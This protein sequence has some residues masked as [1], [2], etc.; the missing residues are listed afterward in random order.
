MYMV[1]RELHFSYGHRLLNYHGKCM[2][3]HGHNARLEID[4]G[5]D[6][7]DP[8]GM[9]MDFGDVKAV[10]QS[11]I[12]K[13]LDHRMIL[14]RDDPLLP[15]LQSMGEPCYVVFLSPRQHQRIDFASMTLFQ[16]RWQL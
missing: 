3:P 5:A 7:L 11:W 6:E 10:I 9:V 8:R 2:H 12:D 13:E 15:A 14:R 1:T 16:K 4:L